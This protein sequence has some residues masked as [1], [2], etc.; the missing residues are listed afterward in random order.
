MCDGKLLGGKTCKTQGFDGGTLTC[1]TDCYAIV[2]SGCYKCG[3]KKK[4][5]PEACDSADLGG[6]TCKSSGFIGGTLKCKTDCSALDTSGCY[7]CGDGKINGTEGCDGTALGGKSCTGLG[8]GAGTL[9]CASDC[10]L[11]Y[12]SCLQAGLEAYYSFDQDSAA[13]TL[14]SSSKN[15]HGV[16]MNV[17]TSSTN[18]LMGKAAFF[19]GSN[20]CISSGLGA[21]TSYSTL[22][23]SFWI[24][25]GFKSSGW[26][27][28][29]TSGGDF[30]AS[31]GST[32][33]SHFRIGGCGSAHSNC[34]SKFSVD[35]LAISANS[36][37]Y[38]AADDGSWHMLT[39]VFD[40][41][42]GKWR[43]Y[44]DDLSAEIMHASFTKGTKVT[45]KY[46]F[47]IGCRAKGV[48][49]FDTHVLAHM[50]EVGV[51]SR[52][53][54][55]KE[56]LWLYN[57][58][59]GRR[60]ILVGCG[61]GVKNGTEQC[62]GSDLGGATCKS[63][64][65]SAGGILRC[66]TSCKL[67]TTYCSTTDAYGTWARIQAGTFLM[68]SPSTESCRN[69]SNEKQH[70]VT[71]TQDFEVAVTETT[72]DQYKTIMGTSPSSSCSGGC[73]VEQ[74]TWHKAAE[75]AN[76]LSDKKGYVKCYKCSSGSCSVYPSYAGAKIYSCPGYRL[77]TEAEWEFA[78]RAGT[79]T[80]F[81]NGDITKCGVDPKVDKIGWYAH[82]SGNKS[83][84]PVGKWAP[85]KWGLYD[86]SGNVRE[87][88]HDMYKADLGS[89][90]VTDPVE[91]G[92][93][94]RA[95][96]G[97][98]WG[99]S[100][101]ALR[102]A[103]RSFLSATSKDHHTGFRVVRSLPP[104]T[105]W[106]TVKAGTFQMGSPSS[107]AE[108]CRQ[109]NETQHKVT[110]TRDFEIAAT[111][112]TQA[113]FSH[114]MAYNP[115]GFSTCGP[116]C[117]VEK[118]NWHEAVAYC[119]ALSKKAGKTECYKCSGSGTTASCSD[120]LSYTGAKIYT[121][122]GYRLPTEAEWEYAYRAGTTNA[123]YNGSISSCS[124]ADAN[125][126]KIGWYDEDADKKTH[127]VAQKMANNWGLYD[128]AGNVWEW[129]HD[130]YEANLGSSAVSDPVKT[131]SS[132]KV[133]RGASFGD[134][135]DR[136]RAA[137]RYSNS[138]TTSQDAYGFRCVRTLQ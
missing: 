64:G 73:P 101:D 57:S 81:Y 24:R 137:Y 4:S 28:T 53:L 103:S 74:V 50:D 121:C 102:A 20:A 55:Q 82:N 7:K 70:A 104:K 59:K 8:Y 21:G 99:N 108:K 30:F 85:N 89:L 6:A 93:G 128:M 27:A 40:S 130:G 76:K 117:P 61:D 127:Q 96:R 120:A 131:V 18:S 106:V 90:Q 118:V 138:P 114:L 51:W 15:R 77:P 113:Q 66:D 98:W 5:G 112:T 49:S 1:K 87:W 110:L 126:G 69:T 26:S 45:P 31:E 14:D 2:T 100:A 41:S 60:P 36:N 56:R 46:N 119:N 54:N 132:S 58:G 19:N 94:P 86:M 88:C 29:T 79:T 124:A 133:L 34:A 42:T 12:A 25:S 9:K 44:L 10:S 116:T 136:L 115:S 75:Y 125:A 84:R 37:S 35:L 48:S 111:E 78:Y 135:A 91:F 39:L 62:D 11:D 83:S 65:F 47:A 16:A 92:T 32:N 43:M 134:T 3:D 72:Q 107:P 109:A 123:F 68:G 80:P 129:C 105:K 63:K 52:L 122:P 67:D 97:G 17:S 38:K 71:L 95:L 22:T 23:V 13:A 33:A